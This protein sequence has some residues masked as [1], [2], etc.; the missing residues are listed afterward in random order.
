MRIGIIHGFD[1]GYFHTEYAKK[2]LEEI[3]G[4]GHEGVDISTNEIGL[5]AGVSSAYL[6]PHA[7]MLDFE[8]LSRTLPLINS[9]ASQ[10]AAM[11]K[12]ETSRRLVK[13]NIPTPETV[14]SNNFSDIAD[15][16]NEKGTI[17]LKYPFGC[18][19]FGHFVVYKDGGIAATTTKGRYPI[20]ERSDH[21][22]IG[23]ETVVPPYYAQEFISF[24]GDTR[25]NDR[26]FRLYVVGDKVR[27]ATLRIKDGVEKPEESIINIAQGAHYEFIRDIEPG[28][29]S[30]ALRVADVVGFDVGVV[31]LLVSSTGKYYV[32]ECD[33][34]GRY[35][36]VDR[37]FSELPGFSNNFNFNRMIAQRLVDIGNGG[38]YRGQPF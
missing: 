34:D 28:M 2:I 14:I 4:L 12:I 32:I 10:A 30:A 24:K 15:L 16:I 6:I 19:G 27:M 35:S 36:A 1:G 7:L 25:S 5:V 22:V 26:V 23:E 13:N 20:E 31:D 11:N 33:C 29:A 18:A 17:M 37:K 21:L 38:G 3:C 9:Y 8:Q